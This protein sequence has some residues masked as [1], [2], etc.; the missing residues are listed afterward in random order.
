MTE[1]L[2]E[3]A[4]ARFFHPGTMGVMLPGRVLKLA[5]GRALVRFD[6]PHHNGNRDFWV[7][8]KHFLRGRT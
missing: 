1:T 8:A 5:E 4:R 6:T 2:Q 3:G 7:D